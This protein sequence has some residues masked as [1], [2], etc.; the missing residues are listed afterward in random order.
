MIFIIYQVNDHTSRLLPSAAWH[1]LRL[2]LYTLA[3]NYMNTFSLMS[4]I[5]IKTI[6]VFVNLSEPLLS[7]CNLLLTAKG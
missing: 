6:F 4:Y 7:Y 3:L 2:M 1:Y 5:H